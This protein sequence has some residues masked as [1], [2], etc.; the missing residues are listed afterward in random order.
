MSLSL[1]LCNI[2][3]CLV[4]TANGRGNAQKTVKGAEVEVGSDINIREGEAAAVVSVRQPQL[5]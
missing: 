3:S 4:P 1:G 2:T 5:T